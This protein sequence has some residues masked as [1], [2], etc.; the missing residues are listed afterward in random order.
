MIVYEVSFFKVIEV[1]NG[2]FKNICFFK[3][4]FLILKR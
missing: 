4:F 2:Y 1:K 3:Y